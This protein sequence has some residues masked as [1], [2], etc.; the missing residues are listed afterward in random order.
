MKG[1]FRGIFLWLGIFLMAFA[2]FNSYIE[3]NSSS[4]P[5]NLPLSEF[6]R[7]VDSGR[8]T[9]VAM[10]GYKITGKL[11][12]GR[13]F[14]TYSHPQYTSL[15]NKVV[16]KSRLTVL[17]IEDGYWSIL[18][19]I[20]SWAPIL[21]LIALYIISFRRMQGGGSKA[22]GFGRSKAK[23]QKDKVG[24]KFSD[25]AGIDES[26][27]ELVE[28]VE[29][30]RD[31]EKFTKL[32]AKIPKGVLLVGQP[33]TGKTLLAKAVAGEAKVAFFSISGSD[34]VEMF[35]GVGASRVR[36]MF[37]EAKK[38]S[39]CILF[40]DEIDAVGRRRGSGTGG[41]HD[42][43]E[44]TLNQLLVEM[45]GFED[46]DKIVIMAATNRS[47]V[48]DPA[49]LRRGRFDRIV[50]V[51]LPDV[52]GREE[53][54]LVHMKNVK[55]ANDVV[56]KDIARTTSGF[57]G[58]DLSNL[59]NEAAILAV[60]RGKKNIEMI[61][62]DDS[63]EKI[64]MGKERR[65]IVVTEKEK[66][67]TAYH[68]GGHA[69]VGYFMQNQ[70]PHKAT[71]VPRANGALGYVAT[72]PSDSQFMMSKKELKTRICV[73][74][75]G[76]LAEEIIFG[77]E[78]ITTGAQSDLK[79]ANGVAKAMVVTYGMSEL[80]M[81]YFDGDSS[82]FEVSDD[83]KGKI[84]DQINNIL[85]ECREIAF[86]LLNGKIDKLHSIKKYLI[87]METLNSEQIASICESGF[88]NDDVK[89]KS[90]HGEL[91]SSENSI[92]EKSI[93]GISKSD[94]A[95]RDG[96]GNNKSNDALEKSSKSS[97]DSNSKKVTNGIKDGNNT[98]KIADK[99]RDNKASKKS[100]KT[101]ENK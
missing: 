2:A 74:L 99:N 28:I 85:K 1:I 86:K 34:F 6:I 65:S 100:S 27:S 88:I 23:L 75:A 45:D 39:P 4:E 76:R 90:E 57:S 41:G 95:N 98:D 33:G 26:K 47:D 53:I 60:L 42:E 94:G 29:F 80:G 25:V 11:Y 40:I 43:R 15:L 50:N 19:M 91:V 44:Q 48:L 37:T 18:S 30:L 67:I 49:L 3:K 7:E 78:N 58:A 10:K 63:V 97:N 92:N 16:E 89:L 70:K 46:R 51:S 83:I 69:L 21:V 79:S 96:N 31:P 5:M 72:L 82:P 24:V 93:N 35:V 81:I 71:I 73:A 14:S 62:F 22:M 101:R 13:V 9:D 59:V 20:L 87:E 52:K 68:E 8:V 61:D 84:D 12:D 55:L 54:L 17:P 64:V 77:E 38:H 36:D 66:E 32:G 56:P